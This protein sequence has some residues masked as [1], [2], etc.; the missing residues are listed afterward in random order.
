MSFSQVV[1]ASSRRS[2]DR[3]LAVPRTSS[4]MPSVTMNG[5]T[6]RRVMSR[7]LTRPQIAPAPIPAAAAAIGL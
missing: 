2:P 6:R 4:I 5:T 3:P 7:P 1:G